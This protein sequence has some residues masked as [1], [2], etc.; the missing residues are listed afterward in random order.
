MLKKDLLVKLYSHQHLSSNE[1]EE[2]MEYIT[3]GNVTPNEISTI[4]MF[5]KIN[6]ITTEELR[7]FRTV[8]IR[9]CIPFCIP[10]NAIDV[11]GTGGDEKNTFNIS[12]LSALVIAACGHKVVKHG[13]YGAS[14]I[15]GSSNILE[16]FGYKFTNDK[17]MLMEQ[18]E[19][20][21]ICFLH[22]PLFHPALKHVAPIRK[23]LGTRTFFNLLGPLVN[24]C[25]ISHQFIGVDSLETMR[26]YHYLLQ[27][28]KT[29][30]TLVHSLDGYDEISL[31]GSFK[32]IENN[33]ERVIHTTEL[34]FQP[35][36]PDELYSGKTMRESS[37]IFMNVLN[38]S[39]SKA[40]TNAVIINSA[41]AI[42]TIT[43]NNIGECIKQATEALQS[44]RT[45][46]L[47]NN[48]T[49]PTHEYA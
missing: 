44:K 48:L 12:T 22:A 1:A 37:A 45:L 9:K 20:N 29:G 43:K 14:S 24:P 17:D 4:I 38:D 41:F 30:F 3:H 27:S 11:C 31:T 16:H 49:R 32:V 40:Q 2:L 8:L 23:E 10:F 39:A 13:N 46:K 33:L 19:Q 47:F 28:G 35:I 26:N 36:K 34:G 25:N 7:S 6:S 18:L 5:Y 21:N 42:R 15:S